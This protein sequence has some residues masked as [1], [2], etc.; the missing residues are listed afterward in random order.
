MGGAVTCKPSPPRPS[1]GDVGLAR[2]FGPQQQGRN[3]AAGAAGGGFAGTMAYAAPEAFLGQP[4]TAKSDVYSM[5]VL[6]W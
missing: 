2:L 6:L 5:G 4:L 1:V 3:G